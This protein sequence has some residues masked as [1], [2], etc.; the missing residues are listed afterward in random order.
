[1]FYFFTG[2]STLELFAD[3][4]RGRTAERRR[5]AP[6]QDTL[7]TLLSAGQPARCSPHTLHGAYPPPL[8]AYPQYFEGGGFAFF[9]PSLSAFF[10]SCLLIL[11]FPHTTPL[12]LFPR[13]H[14]SLHFL[15]PP[16]SSSH[17]HHH[18]RF[19]VFLPLHFLSRRLDRKIAFLFF[20]PLVFPFTP[21]P[22]SL[23]SSLCVLKRWY[24]SYRRPRFSRLSSNCLRFSHLSLIYLHRFLSLSA[25]QP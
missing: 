6:T 14:I 3:R 18:P 17:N 19:L 12:S 13:L 5:F 16:P 21:V 10:F 15:S 20:F 1:M 11:S 23:S 4:R 24:R 2:A 22:P 25:L 8:F 9:F 7:H